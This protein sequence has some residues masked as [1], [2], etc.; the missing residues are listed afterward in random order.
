MVT[1]I[2]LNSAYTKYILPERSLYK[3]YLQSS[4]PKLNKTQTSEQDINAYA[5]VY[6]NKQDGVDIVSVA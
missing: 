5:I 1:F 4:V 2:W 6:K 3:E